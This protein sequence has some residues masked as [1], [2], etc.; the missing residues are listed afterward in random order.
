MD[1]GI[2]ALRLHDNHHFSCCMFMFVSLFKASNGEWERDA[3]GRRGEAEGRA[4]PCIIRQ[5]KYFT[6]MQKAR[7]GVCGI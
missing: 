7:A 6:T 4:T 2:Q 3:C 1:L 5:V